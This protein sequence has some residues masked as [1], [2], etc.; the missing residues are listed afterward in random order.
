LA[1]AGTG[2]AMTG[3]VQEQVYFANTN[4]ST[5]QRQAL[6]RNQGTAY[7]ITVA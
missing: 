2:S 3:Y 5:T 6:E 1:A 4:I 7:G